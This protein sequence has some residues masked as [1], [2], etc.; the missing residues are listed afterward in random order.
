[1]ME[2]WASDGILE[3]RIAYP[4]QAQNMQYRLLNRNGWINLP[5]TGNN[6]RHR[7]SLYKRSHIFDFVAVICYFLGNKLVTYKT[8]RKQR[9]SSSG[10]N[11]IESRFYFQGI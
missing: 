3:K 7:L 5:Q 1:M 6:R 10:R 11:K 2:I 9:F 4:N 8:W